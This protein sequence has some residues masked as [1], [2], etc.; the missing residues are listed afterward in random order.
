MGQQTQILLGASSG[1]AQ[2]REWVP[3]PLMVWRVRPHT[4]PSR[5]YEPPLVSS[6]LPSGYYGGLPL[7]R[8][9]WCTSAM[10]APDC[11]QAHADKQVKVVMAK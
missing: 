6:A 2:E 5:V 1:W 3:R 11:Y 9:P 7:P 8:E 4:I 10:R